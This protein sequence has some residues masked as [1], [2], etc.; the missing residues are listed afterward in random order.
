M[1]DLKKE[2]VRNPGDD[3]DGAEI[4][5]D[6]GRQLSQRISSRSISRG[7]SRIGDSSRHSFSFSMSVPATVSVLEAADGEP[8]TP[9]SS[10]SKV[11][12]KVLFCRLA[13][14]NKPEIP[15]LLFGSLAAVVNGAILPLFGLLFS[16]VIETFYQPPHKLRKD[17]KFWALMFIVLGLASLLATPLRTYFFSVAGCKLIKRIRLMCFEKVVHMEISWFDRTEN[18]TGAICS[19][20]SSDATSVRNLVGES[21]ALLV[22]NIATAIAG[23]IIGFGASWQ[24]S[25]II[26]IMVPLIGLNGYLQMKFIDGFSGDTKVSSLN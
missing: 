16:S 9:A 6:S 25:L 12:H 19:R 11:E 18:S 21:L 1:Q 7:S 23:L 15:E 14:L 22:Q 5:V 17:S 13:Y 26:M 2:S 10:K 20:L 4:N 24:L 8:H 3:K